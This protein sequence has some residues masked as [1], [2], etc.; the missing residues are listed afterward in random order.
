MLKAA[1]TQGNAHR[2]VAFF[3]GFLAEE[4]AVAPAKA[5]PGRRTEKVAKVPLETLAAPGRAKAAAATSAP[6]EKPIITRAQI[7]Q[8]Y[9]DVAAGRYRGR[10]EERRKQEEAIFAAQSDGRIR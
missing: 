9:A 3:N 1:Y 6:A 7:T 2:V 5:E 4:A 10:D 8:F